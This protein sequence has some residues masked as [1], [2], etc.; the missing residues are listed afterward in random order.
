MPDNGLHPLE[1]LMRERVV[2]LD[3]A[4]GTMVQQ[5]RL[6]E[7]E[8]RGDRF[9][10]W[11]GKDLKGCLE[12]LL[13]TRPEV[14]ADIH[15][16]YLEAGADIIETNTFSGTSIGLHDFLFRGE[17]TGKRKDIEFFQRVVDDA[18]LSALVS[19]INLQ[20]A[21][22]ARLV[23]D[24][25]TEK[26][27]R[28]RFVGGSIGPLPVAASLSPDVNDP[29]FRAANFD[30]IRKAYSAQVA[31]LLEGG[32][33]LLLVDTT[34]DTLNAKAA[35]AAISELF[36]TTG[37]R[38]PLII[39]GTVTDRSGRILSGQTVEAFLISIAHANPVV[40]GLNCALGP[41]EM[42]PYIE[43][44]AHA[45]ET[46]VAAYP[47]AGLPDPLSPTGFPETPESLAPQLKKW[48]GNGWL[49][50]VGGCCGTTPDHIRLLAEHVRDLPPRRVE[51]KAPGSARASRADFGVLAE[52]SSD[53]SYSKRRLPHFERPWAKYAVTFSTRERRALTPAERDLVLKSILYGAE[54]GQYELYVASVMPD[55]VHLLFE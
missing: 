20:A 14:I 49:N 43:E 48:A 15:R 35:I 47:N 36:E 46:Y 51:P 42:E 3:G 38:V 30:Q 52:I 23:A 34:F 10:D 29:S 11:K 25:V 45:A 33:D 53:V 54:H 39:S 28:R 2:V 4:M 44:L 55:H 12:I 50:I 41:A 24:E 7:A 40:V 8:Y 26:T 9:K 6:T 31:S 37:K 19:E 1:S 27:G 32:V 22:I 21:R 5:C 17:P 13:L 16:R 18:E